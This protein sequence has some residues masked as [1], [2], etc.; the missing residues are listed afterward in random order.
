MDLNKIRKELH[1][2][3]ELGFE[4]VKTQK[5]ILQLLENLDGLKIHTF[6]FPG[7]L[8]EYSHGFGKYKF[9]R[10]DMDGLPITEDTNCGFESEHKGKMHACGHDIHMT[11]LIGLIEKIVADNIEENLLFLFQPAEEGKGGATRIIN[12]GIFDK[13]DISEAYALHVNGGMKTGVIAS[14]TGIF[15]AN[16]QEIEVVFRGR[17]AHVA[18]AEKGIN[19]LTAGVEFYFEIENEIRKEF[20]LGKPVICAFGKMNAGVVMNAVPAECILE[21]TF[22][23]FTN[24]DHETLKALIENLKSKIAKKQGVDTE[25]IYKAYYKEVVNDK[26]LFEKLKIIAN[27]TGI[28]F[29]EAEMVFTGEDFGFFTEKYNGLLFWLGVGNK[30]DNADLHSSQFLP[31]EKAIDLGVDIFFHLINKV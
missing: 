19:A 15:F 22:R 17:S 14:R 24:E 16:T 11:I 26:I 29:K 21:G 4:E 7:I 18:F 28:E 25:I 20:P 8:I 12:T 27:E 1:K 2:I 31:D 10:A 9:F 3:P 23:A 13:F 30:K 6:D 5:Y